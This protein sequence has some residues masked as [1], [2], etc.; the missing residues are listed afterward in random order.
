[1]KKETEEGIEVNETKK[2][3]KRK[4][5]ADGENVKEKSGK[6]RAKARKRRKVATKVTVGKKS[7]DKV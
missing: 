4:A 6:K 3:K 7:A 5:N 1:M 2:G